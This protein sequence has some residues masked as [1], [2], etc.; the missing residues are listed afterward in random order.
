MINSERGETVVSPR[1][2]FY[3]NL[4]SSFVSFNLEE[5]KP[6]GDRLLSKR[7]QNIEALR[8]T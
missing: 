2:E 1:S 7:L 5:A 4:S 6:M 8:K 3:G